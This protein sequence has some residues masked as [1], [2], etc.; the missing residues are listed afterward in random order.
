MFAPE[1]QI[2]YVSHSPVFAQCLEQCLTHNRCAKK[3]GGASDFTDEET[4]AQGKLTVQ[5]HSYFIQEILTGNLVSTTL[6]A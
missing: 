3:A 6:G 5:G 1:W 2:L 4:E